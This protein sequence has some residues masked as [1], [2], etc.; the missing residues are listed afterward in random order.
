MKITFYRT[1]AGAS[2]VEKYLVDLDSKERAAVADALKAI[3]ISGL[4]AAG[5]PQIHRDSA[6]LGHFCDA[7]PGRS[8]AKGPRAVC[9]PLPTCSTCLRAMQPR[10]DQESDQRDLVSGA[11]ERRASARPDRF[12]SWSIL[13]RQVRGGQGAARGE[14]L[15]RPALRRASGSLANPRD[16]RA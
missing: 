8:V 3:E 1:A 9:L 11:S 15:P 2:P 16:Q 14:S 10:H 12:M 13:V 6:R 5:L 4:R 7:L